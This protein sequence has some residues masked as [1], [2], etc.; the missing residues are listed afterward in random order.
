MPSQGGRSKRG[1]GAAALYRP[2]ERGCSRWDRSAAE[3]HCPRAVAGDTF[4]GALVRAAGE[5]V[6]SYSIN[7]NALASG[8][9]L[10][11]A[12]DGV[13]SISGRP[14]TLT[15]DANTKVYANADPSLTYTVEAAGASRGLVAGDSFTGALTRSAGENVGSYT[16]NANA[17]RNGNY[18][19][20]ASNGALTIS[21]RPI[22]LAADAKTK[23]YGSADPALTFTAEAAGAS[24]GLVAGD[25]VGSY[26]INAN[27]LANGNYVISATN[28]ALSISKAQLTVTA[29]DQARLYGA[30]NPVFTQT[31]TGFVNG[32]TR[33]VV[34][35]SANATSTANGITPVGYAVISANA[36]G[37]VATNYDFTKLVDGTLAITAQ[38]GA[39]K[40]AITSALSATSVKLAGGN[41]DEVLQQ[42]DEPASFGYRFNGNGKRSLARLNLKVVNNGIKLP[43]AV[44]LGE[45]PED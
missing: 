35:G 3:L 40:D 34:S 29:D 7:G 44:Q 41:R 16:I 37:L 43:D 32:D 2:R 12:L 13:L 27:A 1:N 30:V 39:I 28:G 14:I 21:A 6:G 38:D 10:I 5:N 22:T 9:Y 33:A 8:N 17:L 45:V 11:T 18:L 19:I 42:G 20:T 26:T 15:A 31:V 25:N 36:T 23:V 24:R 4:A